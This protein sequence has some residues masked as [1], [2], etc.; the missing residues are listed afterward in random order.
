M[1]CTIAACGK[2]EGGEEDDSAVTAAETPMETEPET[3]YID[4]LGV[5]DFDGASYII[6]AR[7]EAMIPTLNMQCGELTGEILNDTQFNRDRE[8]EE[9]YNVTIEYPEWASTDGW[10]RPFAVPY[11]RGI[12][13]VMCTWIPSTSAIPDWVPLVQQGVLY[14]LLEVPHL[15]WIGNGGVP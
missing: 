13:F 15:R 3:T 6:Y 7:Y 8:I 10:L 14:N 12:R 1:L 9:A 2:G 11:R 4:T 5:R